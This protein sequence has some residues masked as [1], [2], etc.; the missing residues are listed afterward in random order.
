MVI[1][2]I[3]TLDETI[4]TLSQNIDRMH[5]HAEASEEV[6]LNSP[7]YDIAQFAIG[8]YKEEVEKLLNEALSQLGN[9]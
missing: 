6:E 8:R 4:Q 3:E 1:A 7:D 9:I 2:E 5:D